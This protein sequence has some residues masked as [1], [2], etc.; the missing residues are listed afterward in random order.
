MEEKWAVVITREDR[1]NYC[2]MKLGMERNNILKRFRI[3]YYSI[4]L[5][6]SK[7]AKHE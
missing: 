2:N 6:G 4:N 7:A 5:S 1:I 3:K